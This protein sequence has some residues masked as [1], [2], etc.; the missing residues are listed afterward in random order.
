MKSKVQVTVECDEFI[1]QEELDARMR[2]LGVEHMLEF[3]ERIDCVH[4]T[5]AKHDGVVGYA[6]FY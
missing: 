1:T 3:M 4:M 5:G 6:L 2:E